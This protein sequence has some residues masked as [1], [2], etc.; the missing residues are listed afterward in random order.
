M[1]KKVLISIAILL[2]IGLGVWKVFFSGETIK[3]KIENIG[4][5]LTSYNIEGNMEI[6]NGEEKRNYNVK[7]SY[8]KGEEDYFKVS[9]YDTSI[10]QEQI[11]LRNSEGVYVLTPSLN[12]AQKFKSGWPLSSAKPYIYQSLLSVFDGEY[13]LE[14]LEDGFIVRSDISYKNSPTYAKQEIK[15][16]TEFVP[17]WI[18][19]YDDKDHRCEF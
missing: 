7:V 18:N 5:N 6:I 2:V 12:M 16:S 17:V 15:F 19:I 11:L 9:L 10:N 4:E 13:E 14:K 1:L 3:E 8:L